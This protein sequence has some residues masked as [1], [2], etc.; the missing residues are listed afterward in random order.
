MN[1]IDIDNLSKEELKAAIANVLGYTVSE[2]PTGGN[3]FFDPDGNLIDIPDW[4]TDIAA[5]WE[6]DGDGWLWRTI[7]T[8]YGVEV[9]NQFASAYVLFADFPTKSAAYAIARCRTWLKAKYAE[10]PTSPYK[11]C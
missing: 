1:N 7:E 5:A 3:W 4:P 2:Y 10:R 8:P 6:L 11:Q 9:F